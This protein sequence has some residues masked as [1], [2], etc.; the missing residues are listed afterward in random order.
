MSVPHSSSALVLAGASV[1]LFCLILGLAQ[2]FWILLRQSFSD[3]IGGNRARLLRTCPLAISGAIST[4]NLVSSV[5]IFKEQ[6]HV[7]V[8]QKSATAIAVVHGGLYWAYTHMEGV[9][10]PFKPTN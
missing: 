3:R 8:V 1:S 10:L 7:D 9:F 4:V 2:L 6:L 5:T